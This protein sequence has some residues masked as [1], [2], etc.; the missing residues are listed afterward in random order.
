M[1]STDLSLPEPFLA[2][3]QATDGVFTIVRQPDGNYI[4]ATRKN[5]ALIHVRDI[6]P[7][8]VLTQLITHE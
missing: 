4:G 6:D 2:V 1:S 5:G 8:T 3:M 7:N